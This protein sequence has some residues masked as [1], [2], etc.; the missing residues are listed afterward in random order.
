MLSYTGAGTQPSDYRLDVYDANAGTR[1]VRNT[2][3]AVGR[4]VVDKFRG[5]YSLNRETVKGSPI[6]EPSVSVWAPSP[7]PAL[8][9]PLPHVT[10]ARIIR[11]ISGLSGVPHGAKKALLVSLE[12][13][14][15]ELSRG[16]RHGVEKELNAFL[17]KLAALHGVDPASIAVLMNQARIL[18]AAL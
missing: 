13:L 15:Q 14:R 7:P 16:S 12:R 5:L 8:A 4:I 10:L 18:G 17:H 3:I 11:Y 6:V 9:V 2:G 1:V